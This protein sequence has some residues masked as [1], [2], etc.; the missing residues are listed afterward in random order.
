MES[1]CYQGKITHYEIIEALWDIRHVNRK[2]RIA[3][4]QVQLLDNHI[5]EI[6]NRLQRYDFAC[7]KNTGYCL[8]LRL[9]T[10]QNLRQKFFIYAGYQADLLESLQ[11]NFVELSGLPEW[12]NHLLTDP[13]LSHYTAD[14]ELEDN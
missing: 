5:K 9:L 3:S 11:I 8:G 10:L 6:K 7:Q 14:I 2:F 1:K 13:E 4:S 12:N